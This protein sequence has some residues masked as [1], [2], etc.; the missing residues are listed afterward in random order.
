MQLVPEM[1]PSPELL[2]L[3]R[4]LQNEKPKDLAGLREVPVSMYLE[5][6]TLIRSQGDFPMTQGYF[7]APNVMFCGHWITPDGISK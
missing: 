3:I 2:A 5:A 1:N 6:I 7:S 4:V